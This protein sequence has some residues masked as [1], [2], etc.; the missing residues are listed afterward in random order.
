MKNHEV[1]KM[2]IQIT[3]LEPFPD[4]P[5]YGLSNGRVV[6]I[7]NELANVVWSPPVSKLKALVA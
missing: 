6:Q 1:P 7:T 5:L 4:Q 2:S 3:E